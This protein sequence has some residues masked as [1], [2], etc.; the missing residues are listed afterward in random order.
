MNWFRCTGGN[1]GGGG[2]GGSQLTKLIDWE[3][4]VHPNAFDSIA[5]PANYSNYTHLLLATTSPNCNLEFYDDLMEAAFKF[6]KDNNN[7]LP[8]GYG[9]V[10]CVVQTSAITS[11]DSTIYVPILW[12]Y[13]GW[14]NAFAT[15]RSSKTL[16]NSSRILGLEYSGSWTTLKLAM[17]GVNL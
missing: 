5:M 16:I 10:F 11:S 12:P 15:D 7:A 6:Y 3:Q 8:G 14:T 4:Y 17:Y 1:S 9:N 13:L 2:G